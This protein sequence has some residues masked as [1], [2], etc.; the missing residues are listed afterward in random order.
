MVC[1][2]YSWPFAVSFVWLSCY[3]LKTNNP[4]FIL[5]LQLYGYYGMPFYVNHVMEKDL[6]FFP[7]L[8]TS[9]ILESRRQ[10][11]KTPERWNLLFLYQTLSSFLGYYVLSARLCFIFSFLPIRLQSKLICLVHKKVTVRI[12]GELLGK[13]SFTCVWY[14]SCIGSWAKAANR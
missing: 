13:C 7:R 1:V 2:T 8:T 12:V 11:N 6:R 14:L 5:P 4:D 10:S 3:S 9:S